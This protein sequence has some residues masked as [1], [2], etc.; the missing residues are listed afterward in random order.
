L[1]I[2]TGRSVN[3]AERLRYHGDQFYLKTG[4]EMMQVFGGEFPDA[5]SNTVRI[6]DRCDVDLSG[7]E[8]HLPNFDVPAGYTLDDYFE[9]V[10]RDGF[11]ERLV[12]LQQLTAAGSLRHSI[13]EYEQR[14]GYEI[15]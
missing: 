3:D 13:G 11:A 14:L 5:I 6:A 4:D 8:N 2:G 10:V 12:R 7:A 9:H 15:E 1:C